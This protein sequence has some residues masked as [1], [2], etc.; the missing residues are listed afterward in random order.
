MRVRKL[1]ALTK[2]VLGVALL[3]TLGN[4]G[5]FRGGEALAHTYS[6]TNFQ[7]FGKAQNLTGGL[8]PG[9]SVHLTSQCTTYPDCPYTNITESGID[10]MPNVPLKFNQ[11]TDL[12]TDFRIDGGDCGGGSPRFEISIDTDGDGVSDGNI[13]V[14]IGPQPNFVN[15]VWGWQNTGNLTDITN[16]GLRYDLTDLRGSFFV[17]Y[18]DALALLGDYNVLRVRLVVDGGWTTPRGQAV[19]VD[20]F[21]VNIDF[22]VRSKDTGDGPVLLQRHRLR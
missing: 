5:I 20:N 3:A 15:C 7:L 17:T 2:V 4:W 9:G 21:R 10:Y 1:L 12:S 6:G 14:Y 18:T 22:L 13:F 16:T 11:M 19:D 8:A